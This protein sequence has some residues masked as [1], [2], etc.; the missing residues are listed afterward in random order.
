MTGLKDKIED[1]FPLTPL[2]KGLLFHTLYEP[3]SGVYFEQLHCQ[4]Q[5]E[6]SLVAVRQAWQTLVDRHSIL[7]TAIVTKGQ[8][9]PVQVVFRHLTFNIAEE[10]WRGLSDDAQEEYLNQFLE[11]DKHKGFVLNRPPLMR[12]TLIR[13]REDIW[14]LVWSHHHIILD[15][16][17]WPILLKEFLMLHKA[18]KENVAISLPRVRPYADF[19]AWLKQ[20]NHQ[21]SKKFWQQYMLGF[22]SATALLMISKTRINSK[23]KSGEITREL[24]PEK[25]DLLDKLARNCSVTL[26]TVI[27][28]AWAILLNRYSRSN[29]VVYGITVAGRPPEIP[30]VETMIGP[31]INTLPLRVLISGEE[32][33]DNWL[34]SLQSQVALMRQF[35]HTSLSDI[36]GWSDIPRGKQLFES[37][38]AFENFP[39]DKSLK[40]SDFGLNVPESHFSESTHYPITLVVIPGNVIS[41][42]LSYNENRFDASIMKL[43]LQQFADLLLNMTG[44]PRLFLRDISLLGYQ[45][46]QNL[47]EN[48]EPSELPPAQ[49]TI[50]E[51]FA[52]SVSIYPERIA[53]S[54]EDKKF[55]YQ[56]LD[57]S[58]NTIANYLHTLGIGSE[59]RVVICLE[60]T[61]E[62]I[63]A[64]LSVVKAGGVYV[65]VDPT[66]PPDRI[67]FIIDDCNAGVI[68][69]TSNIDLEFPDRIIRINLD[70]LDINTTY[71]NIFTNKLNRSLS[72][73]T[74]PSVINLNPDSGA[75]IIY[76]SGSTGK[77]KG[78]LV[79]HNNVTR[80]FKSTEDWFKFN[81]EDVWT[82]FHSFAFDFSVW[83]IWGALLYGGRLVIVPYCVSRN[84]QAFVQLLREQEVTVLN[85]TPSAFIQ[86]LACQDLADSFCSLRYIIFGGEALNLGSLSPWFERYGENPT[87]LVNMYGITETTVHV[88]Y[89]PITKQDVDN[90][91]GS[92]IGKPIPDLYISILDPD[93]NHLP[94][95]VIGEMY[96]G[97]AGVARGYLNRPELTAE[98]FIQDTLKPNSR[99][100]RTGDLGR[101]LPDGDLEYL[102]RI[103]S[104]VKIRG[105]RIEIGEIENALAQIP[106]VQENVVIV[107]TDDKTSEKRL[108]AYL[109]CTVEKQPTVK[110]IREHLQSYLPEYM[111]PSQIVYLE[112]FPLTANGKLD[113]KSLPIPQIT[114]ENLGIEFVAPVTKIEQQLASIWHQVLEVEK[115]GRFDNYF[116]LGGDSIRSIRVCSLAQSIGL[117]LKIEQIFSHPVL[118]E[119]AA[120]LET[121]PAAKT[122]NFYEAPFALIA[123][124]DR[125][126]LATIADDAYPL[127]QLQAG[128]LFHGEYSQTS[129]TYHDLFSFRIR[130]SFS[131][132]IWQQAYTEMF[133]R[134]PVLRTA[135]F[136][137]E[138]SQPLQAIV[139]DVSARIIFTDLRDLSASAQEDYIEAF[140]EQE[141]ASRFA[142]NKAPLIRFHIHQLGNDVVEA[143]LVIHHAIMDGWSFAN[144]LY[145]LTGLYLQKMGRGIPALPSASGL[146]YSQFIALEKQALQDQKQKEFWQQQL[147]EIPFTK[148]PRLP[149]MTSWEFIPKV[150]KVDI[151]LTQTTSQG[152]KDIS[153]DL[154]V[155]LRTVLLALHLHIISIFS[156]EEEIV[157]GLV[158]NGRPDTTDSDR[159][160]GLFL[161]TLPLRMKLPHGSW[162]E[163]VKKTWQAEQ[164]IMPNRRFPLAELQRLNSN[165]PLYE[166]SFNFIHFHVYQGLLNWRD[167]ELL[168]SKSFE[169]TNIP[170]AVTWNQE[171][172]TANIS[173]NIT[174]NHSEFTQ[175]QVDNIA[176]C[177][178]TCADLLTQNPLSDREFLLTPQE[179]ITAEQLS[180]SQTITPV[181][182][183]IT[184]QAALNPDV[185]AVVHEGKSWTYQQLNERANQLARFLQHQGVSQEKPVGICLERSLDMV[186][187]MMGVLKAGSCYVPIDPYYPS[188]RIQSMLEDAKVHL[189]LTHSNLKIDCLKSTS[190]ENTHKIIFLDTCSREIEA[191][192]LENLKVPVLANNIAY[193]IFTSGSTGRA[194]GVA[195]PHGALISHQNWFLENFGVN[196]RDVVLQKTPFSFDASV[197]EFWTPLMV[198]AKLVMAKP[199]GHQD[200]L[201]LIRTIQ[202]ENITLL[203]LVPSFLEVILSEAEF[204]QCTSLRLVFSGGEMLK[205]PA[206]QKFR[207]KLS[208]PLVN[209]YGPTETTIDISF[210]HCRE[211]ENNHQIPI[212]EPVSNSKLYIL[213]SLM[214]PVPI[215]TPGNL[216]VSGC[217]LARGYWN[218]PAMTAER[219]LPD[220]FVPGQR[221]YHTGDRARYLPDGK[222]EFLGRVDQQVKIR[223][224]RIEI[225]EIIAALEKQ[226]WVHRAAV[227][228]ISGSQNSPRLVAYLELTTTSAPD[229]WQKILRLELAQILPEYMIP[230]LFF[231]V[232]SWPLLANG[233]IDINSLPDPE[234]STTTAYQDYIAPQTEAQKMLVTLWQQVLKVP[235][236][237]IHDNFFELGGDSIIGLQ[238]IAKA[239]DLGFYF[240]PQDLF[241]YPQVADL[242]AHVRKL[243]DHSFNLPTII[244]G[245]IPFTPIQK[246]F[247]QQSLAHP[248]YWNQAILLDIKPPFNMDNC[249]K[250][251]KQIVNKHSVFQLRFRQ[252]ETGWIQELGHSSQ[253]INWDFIDLTDTP[254]YELSGQLQTIATKFQGQLNLETGLLFRVVYFQT[255]V[256]T[257]DKILLIIH[258]L[259]VDGVSWRVILQDFAENLAQDTPPISPKSKVSV[260]FPQW[261]YYLHQVA[262]NMI[263]DT[264]IN[265]QSD[266]DFWKNQIAA[267]FALPLDFSE[268]HNKENSADQIE[269]NLTEAETDKLLLE[270]PQTRKVRI[271]E[272]LLT[273]LAVTVLEWTG[274]SEMTIALETHGREST[275]E[276]DIS[277]S[278]GWFTSIFPYKLTTQ[279][280]SNDILGHLFGIKQ[281]LS[282]LPNNGLSYGIISQ[283]PEYVDV[284]PPIPPGIIFNYL[285]QFDEQFPPNAPFALAKEDTGI[286]RHP[287][288]QRA[289]QLEITGL[290]VNGKLQMR[291]G[292]SKNLHHEATIRHVADIYQRCLHNLLTICEQEFTSWVPEDF[293]LVNLNQEQLNIVV[294]GVTDLQDVYPLAPVQEGILFHTNYEVEKDIYLQQVTGNII[295]N[296]NIELFKNAWENCISR[297]SSL[298]TS[299]IWRSL[300]R[301]LARVHSRVKLPFIYED[302]S[303][304]DHW[305]Q[306][307]ADFL[308]RDRQEGLSTEIAPLMRLS[309]FRTDHEKWR[310]CWTHHHVL[311]DG[312]SLP[313]VFEDVIAFYQAQQNQRDLN[314]P[315]LPNYRSFISWLNGKPIE[316]AKVFWRGQL[317]GLES[318]T[319]LG[320]TTQKLAPTEDYQILQATLEPKIYSQLKTYANKHQI[321]VSTLVKAAWAILLNKYSRGEEVI[322]GVTVSGRPAELSGFERM[323]GL[324]INTLPLRLNLQADLPIYQWLKSV[325]DRIL[326]INEYSSSSLVDI[327]GWS[328]INRGD[329]L[330][331]SIVIY[332]NYPLSENLDPGDLVINSVE[333]LEKNHYPV[334][335][336]AL[337]GKEDLT[338][339]VAFQKSIGTREERHQ[340]LQHIVD[341]LTTF[342]TKSPEF[343]GEICLPTSS[344][345]PI[346]PQ[347][348]PVVTL[349]DL[350]NQVVL[351]SPDSP[352][353][354]DE[355][356]YLTYRELNNQANQVAQ[357]LI[358]LGVKRETLVAVC[359]ERHVGLAVA[360]L[361][362]MKAGATY[363]PMDPNLPTERWK[364]II[365]DSQATIIL[366]ESS[367]VSQL[368][369]SS[370]TILLLDAIKT[371]P[372]Q[373]IV[374][375]P[376]PLDLAYIIY[377]SGSTGR[378]KGVQIQHQ[379][380]L[381][382]LLSFQEKL[383]LTP[384]DT[385]V[386]VTTISFDIAGLEILLPLI[387]GAK[388]VI[389]NRETTQ[390]GF[391]LAELLQRSQATIMQATPTT[392]QLLLTTDWQP[393]NPFSAICGG[394]AIPQ[395]LAT[396][397]LTLG[398]NLWNVYGPT[399]TTIWSS[400]KKL[401]KPQDAVSIGKEIANTCLYLL[402]SCLN[403]VPQGIVGELYIGGIGLARGYQN[404]PKLTSEKFVPDP[405]TQEPGSRLYRTGDLARW[406]SNG[407]IEFLGR[408][409]YQV[410]IRGHR[411]ELGEIETVL[412]SHPAI[413]Q[414]IVQAIGD[415]AADKKLVA[416]LVAKNQ[417]PT[418]EELRLYLSAK[419]SNYMIPSAWVFIDKVPLTPNNK[420]N[421]R[422]LPIPDYTE[423]QSEYLAPRNPIEE[424]LAYIWQELLKLEKVGVKDNFFYLGGHSLLAG[425]FHG[426]IKKVFAIDL[427]LRELFD[428]VTIE[429]IAILLIEKESKL[430]NTEKIAKAFLRIK[431]M[432]PEEKA[433]LVQKSK[434]EGQN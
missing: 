9:E 400:I 244:T 57:Q 394:E 416:Y 222:I 21:E 199:G 165:L 86:M 421:R 387:S 258:H 18:A 374:I 277:D 332:E 361:G 34:Q 144:F 30:G 134:H 143:T 408:I 305:E 289:F 41:L 156:G 159:V 340:I 218:M 412:S 434:L 278:V 112:G 428:A 76:T 207:E 429:R 232:D 46:R 7:R 246:W 315:K 189:L 285:G 231:K 201:Y 345:I 298:R 313:L 247:F 132:E 343:L 101:F 318:A 325:S 179:V 103:D 220:P 90:S 419:L 360:L 82:F 317:M 89:R 243:E 336:Y 141:Q 27:Q 148:L 152:L 70:T 67:E 120:F 77:P 236:L 74:E 379:S 135:F 252:T 60:R 378:P 48:R 320:L 333:S 157:T 115:I 204:S 1:I 186:C 195:I 234:F 100:Y 409:D 94:K 61:P 397:L 425:Q 213:N 64:M 433:K 137:G 407:E 88:T 239:R 324:F 403:P 17:S 98:R 219:F 432:T 413:N 151:T 349:L 44:N 3:Q 301:P 13:L 85:Q 237:S 19:I 300:P 373:Q 377:T 250:A 14:H 319:S 4:L 24:S 230:A 426:Y 337:P 20:R 371:I 233:K 402:D 367:I 190:Q 359:L 113:R 296:L 97:G 139:K 391:K 16:W 153:H 383:Q 65:P 191:E 183:I 87:R 382:F 311:L 356:K 172:G 390:D 321:T 206:W 31:F 11:A 43:L 158:S 75:Y 411:I 401:E 265:W 363:L 209:L 269:F 66:Y 341:I 210:H 102:G 105:F 68:I 125:E 410:K 344:S 55:T 69:T 92:L 357:A 414:A 109:V 198:G 415:T 130:I 327:Q 352:A 272:V 386:A 284:L 131:L 310:F 175:E 338:L 264:N 297:H 78:V 307:W 242:A 184:E 417:P 389:A 353:V 154:G 211:N 53:L 405:F 303:S 128:M 280:Q 251:I 52:Q 287:E 249:Q 271:Q 37:L 146:E 376:H 133:D 235:R 404:N 95:G 217:Q 351:E 430:G 385:L 12:V 71:V 366:T 424:A 155:P 119:L 23:F 347:I 72:T 238:I 221:M 174:Y 108:V 149:I 123:A 330:F 99:L 79:T 381:N 33:L 261:S 181:H 368:P 202:Q 168:Q 114:R 5:G 306:K 26:N 334:S 163:L 399:E 372:Q 193:I 263:A 354:L 196:N 254:E 240:T 84:P 273:A 329:P 161:N 50:N 147:L 62:L 392:W 245:E 304:I 276:V 293:P 339:K 279:N 200:P 166:T 380:L 32:P 316:E 215:G 274:Q 136:L 187:A 10:D 51:V 328:G 224:F 362:I 127:A 121:V 171:V 167:I 395:E 176:N 294:S 118:A 227:R 45:E 260:G 427:G 253:R 369:E 364:W 38:L 257:N 266:V 384:T 80:L 8:T 173:L 73:G 81:Q 225:N 288:N 431:A 129:T 104:Q 15:G 164:A 212:G 140:I 358:Q 177:Y 295:G 91:S 124:E 145:E 322:F 348:L 365:D 314:L 228:A 256:T 216:F 138:F 229:N 248:E 47:T 188:V 270:I 326:S 58:S 335:V 286:S 180:T 203:Q 25:T 308:T 178:R 205:T 208:V 299:F 418:I 150:G 169:E 116:V 355:E 122:Q 170:F 292:F 346:I 36:Q 29:D 302:W 117:N 182:E 42:K 28:G 396:S 398:I 241:K 54:Y 160:L 107:T 282:R 194:K 63:I 268:N 422:A 192:S 267:N 35:E 40:A 223:G 255:P 56:Q 275:A 162:V 111:I 290:V 2:Q 281:Q 110:I 393:K 323:V 83:E 49:V 185:I 142:Y 214:H 312:W 197:W 375:S 423:E 6:V 350:F 342:A 291:F 388:L 370:A 262:A 406:L 283:K 420:I 96:V 331:E 93:G 259:I 22:E 126:K 59:K 226:S 309:L 39:V 106:D